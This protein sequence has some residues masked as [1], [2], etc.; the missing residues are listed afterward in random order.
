MPK[1]LTTL[2]NR[3]AVKHGPAELGSAAS[4]NHLDGDRAT[5]EAVEL[6]T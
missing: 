5:T 2:D 1:N 4:V 3:H 6:V